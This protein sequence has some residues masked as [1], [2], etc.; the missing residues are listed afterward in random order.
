MAAFYGLILALTPITTSSIALI[1]PVIIVFC[2]I[3]PLS[4]LVFLVILSPLRTLIATEANFPLPLDIGQML[5]AGLIIS[6]FT[7]KVVHGEK[8]ITLYWS[9]VYT[10][11]FVFVLVSGITVFAAWSNTTWLTEWLKWVFI[12]VLMICVMQIGQHNRWQ[13]IILALVT[14]GAANALIGIYIFMGGSGADHLIINNRFFRAFGTFGQPNPFGGFMGL[15]IPISASAVCGYGTLLY[16]R[17]RCEQPHNLSDALQFSFYAICTTV[18]SLALIM[19]WSRG[20]W[21]SFGA[22]ML[23]MAI[24]LPRRWWQSLALSIMLVVI[25]GGIWFAGLVPSSISDRV[26]SATSEIFAFNDIRA[27]DI[28]S[29]NFAVVERLAHW[30]AAI[31]MAQSHPWLGV[32]MGNYEIAYDTYRLINWTEPLGHAHNYYLNI[33]AESGIIGLSAYLAMW[34]TFIGLTWRARKH[35]DFIAHTIVA[36]LMGSWAYLLFHSLTDNLY[37][38][39][40]FLHLG[41]MIGLLAIIERQS[42]HYHRME[43]VE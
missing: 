27:V 22:S 36:G 10:P 40:M 13:W 25:G 28:T 41:I 39:N 18:M 35:P 9:P 38:N 21:L 30:Q 2:G 16:T 23:I 15:L 20:A 19:S 29:A 4:A 37:V 17:W 6:W 34:I 11:L 43:G 1:L 26:N 32:G 7:H 31:E 12:A 24:A 14:A 3:S 33:L 5:V 8:R 42:R